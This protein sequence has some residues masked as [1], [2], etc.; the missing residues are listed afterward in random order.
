MATMKKVKDINVQKELDKKPVTGRFRY[1]ESPGQ[2][3][4]FP[5][6]KYPKE[7]VKIWT[8]VDG[9]IYT[10]PRGIASHLQREGKY[11]VHEHCLD[12]N[13][14]P[15]IRIGHTVDR[16]NFETISFLDEEDEDTPTLYTAEILQEKKPFNKPL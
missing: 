8:F 3:L 16:F 1:N 15:S 12:E 11:Q 4:S 10:I 13:G 6:R 9:E 7:P 2:T 14:K 5:Y